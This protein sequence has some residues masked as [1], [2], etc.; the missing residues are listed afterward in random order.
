MTITKFDPEQWLETATRGLKDYT[1]K[2][3][4]ESV[5]DDGFNWVG[6][7]VYEIVMEYPSTDKLARLLPVA[8]TV[9]HFE[10]DDIDDR[11]LGM[12]EGIFRWNYDPI[13]ASVSPQDASEHRINWDVGI[14]ASDRSGGL[15][16]RLRA[17]QTLKNLFQG[18]I[19]IDALRDATMSYVDGEAESCLE[20]ID[21]SG[22]RFYTDS[23]NDIT[24]YRLINCSLLIRVFSR[25]PKTVEIPTIEE[26]TIIPELI[27]D[28]N[29]Q[30][31]MGVNIY[32]EGTG[33]DTATKS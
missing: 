22:G 29:L 13:R 8:K 16:A 3:F 28:D 7:Q 11:M 21:F 19:A 18:P 15:T 14:W 30:L 32:D 27:I 17:Y 4:Y 10:I 9:I 24:T 5:V 20:I 23:V 25:T 26:I 33:T 12:G 1:E 31:P 6:D 2:G